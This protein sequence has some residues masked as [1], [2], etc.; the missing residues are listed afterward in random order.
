LAGPYHNADNHFT[1]IFTS[2]I[3]KFSLFGIVVGEIIVGEM[4]AGETLRR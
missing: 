4:I 3:S 2:I 1:D